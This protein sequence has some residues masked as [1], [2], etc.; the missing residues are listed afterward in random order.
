MGTRTRFGRG[1]T[2]AVALSVAS[3]LV[4]SACSDDGDSADDADRQEPR[5]PRRHLVRHGKERPRHHPPD[6]RL[7]EQVHADERSRSS[8]C[9]ARTDDARERLVQSLQGAMT[10]ST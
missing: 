7:V 1:G 10:N 8:N 2:F 4:L 9:P 6:R 3:A 5:W